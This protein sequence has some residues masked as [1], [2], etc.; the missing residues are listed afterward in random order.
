MIQ[1]L[2]LMSNFCAGKSSLGKSCTK[3]TFN[4]A[5]KT[6]D[7]DLERLTTIECSLESLA[8]LIVIDMQTADNIAVPG[9]RVGCPQ[10]Q[11]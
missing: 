6:G 5:R 1:K 11:P 10:Q 7:R 3:I 4:R 9:T 2:R 8:W